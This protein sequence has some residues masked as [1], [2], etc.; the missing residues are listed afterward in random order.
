MNHH[1]YRAI[2]MLA[3][4]LIATNAHARYMQSD[5]IGL[6][7]GM[8]TYEY[9]SGAPTEFVDPRGEDIIDDVG[10]AAVGFGDGVSSTLTFGI[11]STADYRRVM[12]IT[13]SH[14]PK[15][16]A[17]AVGNGLGMANA[18]LAVP[19]AAFNPGNKSIFYSGYMAS[20][21]LYGGRPRAI[22]A[23]EEVTNFCSPDRIFIGETIGGR[24]I[25]ELG[26]LVEDTRRM[27]WKLRGNDPFHFPF[28]NFYDEKVS[29]V[30]WNVGSAIYAANAKGNAEVFLV[31]EIAKDSIYVR[32][33]K[34]VLDFFNNTS[35]TI[36][37]ILK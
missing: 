23:A 16:L 20:S 12:N 24:S 13:G 2:S 4:M 18:V 30:L 31:G 9:V 10:S 29:P 33:E 11:F 27:I 6:K 36:T 1:L 17:Y 26:F 14:D 35:R 5:P 21:N 19:V 8:N 34:P 37:H 22:S 3:T 25:T 32:F 7:G 15:S 28:K